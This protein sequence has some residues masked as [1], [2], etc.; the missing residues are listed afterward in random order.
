[1]E[2]TENKQI[3][4]TVKPENFIGRT[5]DSDLLLRHAKGLNESHAMLC[6]SASGLGLTELLKQIYDQ[7]FFE[8]DEIIPIYFGFKQSDKTIKEAAVRFLQTFLRQTVAFRRNDTRILDS[9]PDICELS[10]LAIPSDGYWIDRLITACSQESKLNNENAFVRQAFSSPLRAKHHGAKTFVMLDNLETIEQLS[11]DTD[12]IGEL[13]GIFSRLDLPFVF[14]GKRRFVFAAMQTGNTKL[15]EAEILEIKPLSFADSGLLIENLANQKEIKINDQTRDLIALQFKGNPTFIKL[16]FAAADEK[17]LD[18]NSFQKVEQIYSEELFGGKIKGFY[19]SI[20]DEITPNIEIQKQIIGLLFDAL[21]VEKE[22]V[23]IE[24]WERHLNFETSE[25]YRAMR[26]LNANEIIQMSSNLVGA[27]KE[28]QILTDYVK[29]RFRLEILAGSR[30]LVVGESLAEF[31]RRSSAIGLRELLSVFNCQEIPISLLYYNIYKEIHKGNDSESILEDVR[32]EVEKTHLPQIVY[33]ANTVSLYSPISKL[34]EKERSAV[35]LG[36]EAASYKDEDEIVWI[37]A[38]IDS[39]L[40]AK[41]DLS[42][43]WCD[44]L[45]MV[46][47]MCGFENYRLW[48]ISPEG[49][50]DEAFEILRARRAIG[51]SRKQVEVL[52]KY[53]DAENL[54]NIKSNPNEY[55]MVVPMGE[56]TELIAAHAVEEIA[57]RHSFEPKAINQIKTAL[58]EAFINANEHSHSPDRKIYQKFEVKD[59][60]IL[61]TISN[62]GLRFKGLETKEIKPDKGR[63][64]WG[65]KLMK[66]LMDDVKFEQVDDGTKISMTKLL[67][68]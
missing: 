20:F 52:A 19:D 40:E 33:T 68:K 6:L 28:N 35:A 47:I 45:E 41:A 53:L 36:F 42:R 3:L 31:Y 8:Q 32:N 18:L 11:G 23:P 13:K 60:K 25:F 24:S 59:D 44:R 34:T 9:A 55:E 43:F 10:E 17:G 63:R 4:S 66:S 38:E 15:N 37:A 50:E 48:L 22:K 51:S 56:D 39:K 58:V 27:S 16:M 12:L 54:I 29:S 1:M 21:T 61:I 46:A 2:K 5:K 62:R 26:L 67:V 49:F 14:A 57:R 64:G 65:L 7:I 30:A